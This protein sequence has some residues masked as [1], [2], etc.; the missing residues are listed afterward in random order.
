MMCAGASR[1]VLSARGLLGPVHAAA[2]CARVGLRPTGRVGPTRRRHANPRR[3]ICAYPPVPRERNRPPRAQARAT[4]ER[5]DASQSPSA[6]FPPTSGRSSAPCSATGMPPQRG[7]LTLVGVGLGPACRFVSEGKVGTNWGYALGW[8]TLDSWAPP[9]WST[10]SVLIR[11]TRALR[12]A[13]PK[14]TPTK[15][16]HRAPSAP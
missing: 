13:G 11:A 6:D 5:H 14:P 2:S 10:E 7:P 1:R 15:P 16:D 4:N 8:R 12:R 3:A 9:D